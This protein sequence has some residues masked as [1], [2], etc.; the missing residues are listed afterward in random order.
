MLDSDRNDV[1][2]EEEIEEEQHLREFQAGKYLRKLRGNRSLAD[3]VKYLDISTNY[4]SEVER[5]K[6]P[7]DHFLSQAAEFYEV[8]GDDLFFRWGKIPILAAATIRDNKQ[9][10][11]TLADISRHKDFTDEQKQRLYDSLYKTYKDFLNMLQAEK[12]GANL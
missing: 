11:T 6:M 4:L 8:D 12:E 2:L 9:L 1:N 3:V 10:M 5:G 7:S